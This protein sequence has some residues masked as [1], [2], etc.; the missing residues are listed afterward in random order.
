MKKGFLSI[1][2]IIGAVT[3]ILFVGETLSFGASP[4]MN[5]AKMTGIEI[6]QDGTVTGWAGKYG[7]NIKPNGPLK[8]KRIGVIT[9]SEFSDWQAYYLVSYIGE[10]GGTCEFLLVDWVTWKEVRPNAPT[11]SVH[12]MWGLSVDP[13]PVMGGD[14]PANFKSLKKADPKAYDVVLIMGEHS[15]DVMVTEPPV[16]DFIKAAAANGAVVGGI[17]GG[18]MP[19]ISAGVLHGKKC[20]G[21]RVVD[22]MLKRIGKFENARV[23]VDGKIITGR[24]TAS[25]PEFFRAVCKVVDPS[26]KEPRKGI[27][28]GKKVMIMVLEDFEDIELVVPFLELKYRGAEVVI[29]AFPPETK[30]RPALLGVDVIHGN[31]GVSIPFQE[32]PDSHYRII[33]SKDLKMS[34]FDVLMIPGA[35]NPW[36]IVATGATEFVKEAYGAG[37]IIAAICHGA[38]P[39][40]AADLVKGRKCA[41]WLA[42]KDSVEIMGGQYMADWAA[43]IDGQIVTG[44]TPPEI[45]EFLDAITEALLRHEQ[46]AE[47]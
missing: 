14:K 40:A 36:Q 27:L 46:V 43:G 44:R 22:Y 39:L 19:M 41:G 4:F 31:F 33:K 34:D 12:G 35:F 24:D 23:A 8:G 28:K 45:P 2:G 20:C 37:K 32:I 7:G 25:T 42:C 18:I 29:G 3:L 13:V 15:G 30:S 16:I 6:V 21:N 1:L 26:F 9:A 38:I 5:A 11:K 10:Y 17:G 47:R